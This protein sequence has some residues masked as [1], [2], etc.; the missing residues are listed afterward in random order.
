MSEHGA[1]HAEVNAMTN[2][3][4]AAGLRGLDLERRVA[5]MRQ[6]Q[7]VGLSAR[8]IGQL[9]LAVPVEGKVARHG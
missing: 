9:L 6:F 5:T 7:Q 1:T 8:A 2:A 3:L 4:F